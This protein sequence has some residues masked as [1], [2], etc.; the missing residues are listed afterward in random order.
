ML[1]I[2]SNPHR[3]WRMLTG[4]WSARPAAS[5]NIEKAEVWKKKVENPSPLSINMEQSEER[6]LKRRLL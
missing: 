3:A 1:L 6:R 4:S 2:S 5:K